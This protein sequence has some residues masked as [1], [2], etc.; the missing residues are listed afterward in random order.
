MKSKVEMF[1][2]KIDALTM[3]ET[4]EEIFYRIDCG[5][6]IHHVVVNSSKMVDMMNDKE[7]YDS[8]VNSDLI[9]A[10]GQGVVWA[11]RI[12]GCFI[13]ERVAGIDLMERLIEISHE[14][15]YSIF[16]LGAGS[17]VVEGVV[18]KY[19][20]IYSPSIVAGY[21]DG[22]FTSSEEAGVVD[23][24]AI[25][26]AK[27]LFVAMSSPKKEIFLSKY[28]DD[29]NIPFIMGVGGS[30]DVVSGKIPRAPLWMQSFGLEWFY[31]FL[32]EPKRMWRRSIIK[33]G[34]F[35]F[36]VF[37]EFVKIRVERMFP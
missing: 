22:Y 2:V 32:R 16:F 35:V 26:G 9:N 8:V 4:I 19:K 11:G 15:K 3:E 10:D 12:L 23:E 14:K 27:I 1:N 31:R 5:S 24:L 21:R 37:K 7:L 13:P 25:S 6:F 28:K 29:I 33:N 18:E 20:N 36:L 30:F 17:D 34:R